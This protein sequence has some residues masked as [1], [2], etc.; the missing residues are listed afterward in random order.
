MGRILKRVL[1]TF[2]WPHEKV[3]NGYLRRCGNSDC[4]GCTKCQ[5]IEPPQGEGYQLWETTTEG[6]PISPVF[7]TLDALCAWAAQHAT[8][9]ATQKATKEEWQQL[10][11]T[12]RRSEEHTSELQSR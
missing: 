3:W 11:T 12:G 5:R 1:H 7:A 10:L 6:S 8:V 9:C 2:D 4:D